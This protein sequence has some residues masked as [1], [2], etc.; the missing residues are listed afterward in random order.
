MRTLLRAN[1]VLVA[2]LAGH[3]ADHALHQTGPGLPL[4]A[5]IPGLAGAAAAVASLVATARRETW[6]PVFAALVG[7]A[8]ALGFV[9][10]HIA[11]HWSMFSDPYA[12][13]S[14]DAL[15]WSEMLLTLSAGLYLA[16]T[17]I[18]SPKMPVATAR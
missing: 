12:G 16:I 9:A 10:I 4:A 14:V 3:I 5:S 13:R 11:P 2:L 8:T 17:A 1:V 7:V 6:A 15:S 18:R